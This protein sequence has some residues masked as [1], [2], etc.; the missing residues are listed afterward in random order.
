MPWTIWQES[1]AKRDAAVRA[2]TIAEVERGITAMNMAFPQPQSAKHP[3]YGYDYPYRSYTPMAPT[4]RPDSPV[5]VSTL[6][7]LADTYDVLRD[8]IQHLKREVTAVPIEISVKDGK[9]PSGRAEERIAKAM[10]FLSRKG[11]I[12]GIGVSRSEFEGKLLEDLLVIGAAAVWYHPTVGG[13]VYQCLAIDA[14]TIRPASDAY[15]FP[16]DPPYEQWIQGMKT[17]DYDYSQL[18]YTGLPINANSRSLYYK[19]P[20]EWLINVVNSALRADQWNREWLVSGNTP[21]DMI[22]MPPEWSPDQVIQ[23]AD[24]WDSKLSGETKERVKTKFLPAGSQKVG[25]NTRKDQDFQ[26]FE[27]W[28]LRRTCACMGVQPASIGFA[29]EQY[30]VS[31]NDSMES[32]SAFGA[33][34]ILEWRKAFY[35]D[36]LERLGFPDL[37]VLNIN[38][39]EEKIAERAQRNSTLVSG[40]IKTPNEARQDE[41]LEPIEGGDT[42]FIS[43][44]LRPLE[45]ALEPPEPP[46][47]PGAKPT[48]ANANEPDEDDKQ[49]R[50]AALRLY[51]KKS[52]NRVKAGKPAFCSFESEY[53]PDAGAIAEALRGCNSIDDVREEFRKWA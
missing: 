45:Q 53:L 6:V 42:L 40:A 35:D 34:V 11:G 29:G 43:S 32:T 25:S 16:A 12:G 48:A 9:T 18:S 33:G 7:K 20:V 39:R 31:Q 49:D 28:L 8:C 36:L 27:L 51:E 2:K 47:M 1:L 41:G 21:A 15:G 10:N 23:W 13:S 14:A 30:K 19:S 50:A 46:A 24:Y 3:I 5:T 17:G 52:I 44:T 4:R 26:E 37:E 22:A 38:A